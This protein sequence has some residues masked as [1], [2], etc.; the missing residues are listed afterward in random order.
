MHAAALIVGRGVLFGIGWE[1]G[2]GTAK[3]TSRVTR[4]AA[5]AVV[6]RI[7]RR[8]KNDSASDTGK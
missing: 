7:P 6:E 3:A 2:C 4:K 1:V 5:S 8:K